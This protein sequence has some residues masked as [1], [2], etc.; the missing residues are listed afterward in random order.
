MHYNLFEMINGFPNNFWGHG[1]E[2][3]D[4]QNR[5]MIYNIEIDRSDFNPRYN[6][7]KNNR[8]MIDNFS[9]EAR[10]WSKIDNLKEKHKMVEIKN[11]NLKEIYNYDK[12]IIKMNGISN[13]KYK[14]L[15]NTYI[16]FNVQHIKFDF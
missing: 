5:A 8:K 4:L 7:K 6:W 10:N 15:C 14:I 3:T 13:I 1:G 2:D 16:N 11:N 9:E 12:S